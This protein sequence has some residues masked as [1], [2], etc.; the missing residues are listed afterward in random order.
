MQDEEEG[1]SEGVPVIILKKRNS[2]RPSSA[3]GQK[4][5]YRYIVLFK[6]YK[7]LDGLVRHVIDDGRKI[8]TSDTNHLIIKSSSNE[9]QICL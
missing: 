3:K 4:G 6:N 2:S 8:T 5:K 7:R 9:Y 1:R